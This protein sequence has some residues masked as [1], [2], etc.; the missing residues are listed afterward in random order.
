MPVEELLKRCLRKERKAW[1]EFVRSYDNLVSRSVRYK[2]KSM[3]I[4][5]CG[6]EIEDTVQEIF[7]YIWEKDKL[8]GVSDV[9]C[10]E[11]WIAIVSFNFTSTCH[12]RRDARDIRDTHSLEEFH[13]CDDVSV[14]LGEM[15]ESPT[16]NTEDMVYTNE[17]VDLVEN[18][19]LKLP[20]KQRLAIKFNMYDGKKQKDIAEI[21][22][23]P[24]SH[25]STLIKRA[26]NSI[27]K[28]IKN[29][30]DV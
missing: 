9:S 23:L 17:L 29:I 11:G 28:G 20:V 8:R 14:S 3:N 5:A 27:R 2:L 10:L 13:T 12:M 26:K 16:L 21:M 22:D 30:I 18:E 4:H 19:V 15:L 6:A 1:D 24:I 7:L 25:V